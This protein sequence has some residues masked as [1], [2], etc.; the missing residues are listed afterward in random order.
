VVV[1]VVDAI[2]VLLGRGI[3]GL[4]CRG[5]AIA[6]CFLHSQTKVVWNCRVVRGDCEVGDNGG[7][8]RDHPGECLNSNR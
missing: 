5:Q 6:M 3:A 7:A 2:L 4:S 1:V 8:G